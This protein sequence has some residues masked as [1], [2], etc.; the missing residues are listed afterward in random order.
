MSSFAAAFNNLV[1]L[2][3]G[4]LMVSYT[5]CIGCFVWRRLSGQPMLPS[6]FNMGR[7]GLAINLVSL[8]FLAV[9]FVMAFF[10]PQ[11]SPA[12]TPQNMNW[13]SLVFS[14]IAIWGVVFYYVWARHRYVGP[15]EYVRKLD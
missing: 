3:N 4:T 8:A 12:L 11:P 10:P 15:V 9:V 7:L 13:S 1:S 6:K 5:V 14:T 2:T